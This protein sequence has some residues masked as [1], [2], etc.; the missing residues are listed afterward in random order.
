MA[1]RTAEKSKIRCRRHLAEVCSSTL[2][3]S[4]YATS[5]LRHHCSGF[6]DGAPIP[7]ASSCRLVRRGSEHEHSISLFLDLWPRCPSQFELNAERRGRC[8]V[9]GLLLVAMWAMWY[10][11]SVVET[12]PS[13][14]TGDGDG[15]GLRNCFADIH[16]GADERIQWCEISTC[17]V[18]RY[19]GVVAFTQA[20]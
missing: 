4:H 14:L 18:Y 10:D 6:A 5:T 16:E 3:N 9:C 13:V 2:R 15:M 20:W 7:K 11:M 1:L 8:M 17:V 19:I 12:W